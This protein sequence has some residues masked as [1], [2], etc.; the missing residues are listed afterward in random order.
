MYFRQNCTGSVQ[1]D[2]LSYWTWG[3]LYW[4]F[5][6]NAV[7]NTCLVSRHIFYFLLDGSAQII[8]I[9]SRWLAIAVNSSW[10]LKYAYFLL[11][12]FPTGHLREVH[13]CESGHPDCD[14]RWWR[15]SFFT[16]RHNW[17]HHCPWGKCHWEPQWPVFFFSSSAFFMSWVYWVSKKRDEIKFY[18]NTEGLGTNCWVQECNLLKTRLQ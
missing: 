3:R 1:C 6:S 8:I 10:F 12:M 16:T 9:T 17:L 5:G 13:R 15:R 4:K 18:G 7:P 14:E 2:H 11:L